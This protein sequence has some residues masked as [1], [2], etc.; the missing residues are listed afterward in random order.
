[1]R[2]NTGGVGGGWL[3]GESSSSREHCVV[4]CQSGQVR[5]LSPLPWRRTRAVFT[6]VEVADPQVGD[7]LDPCAGVVEEQE[8]GTVPQ[9]EPAAAG[10]V[11]EQSLDLVAFE[12][13]RFGRRGSLHGD[14]RHP[15]AD[16]EHLGFPAGDVLE[17]GVQGG[18]AL[19]AGADVVAAVVL[20]VAQE[21]RRPVRRSGRRAAAW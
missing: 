18:Q 8:Q 10:Q 9:G 6:E 19:V 13:V 20:Q 3:V 21:R 16:A 11:A 4:W 17:Q 14:G 1:M 15:L 7:L 12:E 5:H 2:A